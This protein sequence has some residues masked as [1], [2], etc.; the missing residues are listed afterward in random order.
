MK[1]RISVLI[2]S[3]LI[4][5]VLVM[6]G[7][8][9]EGNSVQNSKEPQLT[10]EPTAEPTAEPTPT[11]TPE[12]TATP[13][14]TPEPTATPIPEDWY[15]DDTGNIPTDVHMLYPPFGPTVRSQY[16]V[17]ENEEGG[18]ILQQWVEY[19]LVKE[20]NIPK[21]MFEVGAFTNLYGGL[22]NKDGVEVLDICLYY[23]QDTE[24][25]GIVDTEVL[26][27]Q[28]E[29]KEITII[30][31]SSSLVPCEGTLY[32]CSDGSVYFV[33]VGGVDTPVYTVYYWK[34]EPGVYVQDH[35]LY[36]A[37]GTS[38]GYLYWD[39]WDEDN[40]YY[41]IGGVPGTIYEW[42]DIAK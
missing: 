35:Y 8:T 15:I 10:L 28:K 12:P 29:N 4:A 41:D 5:A 25:K 7:C 32:A 16:C 2:A 23:G 36:E 22:S 27:L 37:D 38:I 31:N 6:A 26:Y 24:D 42:D 20:W 34:F 21:E 9:A 14:P 40:Q 3:L 19:K 18:F 30:Y 1:H 13:T 39:N 11:P 17:I 33:Y